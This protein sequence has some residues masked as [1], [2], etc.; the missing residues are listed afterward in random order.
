MEYVVFHAFCVVFLY[1]V[2]QFQVKKQVTCWKTTRH[3]ERLNASKNLGKN[4]RN[5]LQE[6]CCARQIT[7]TSLIAKSTKKTALTNLLAVTSELLDWRMC[8]LAKQGEAAILQERGKGAKCHPEGKRNKEEQG[9]HGGIIS[10]CYKQ[11]PAAQGSCSSTGVLHTWSCKKKNVAVFFVCFI[12]KRP[13]I[14]S[15]SAPFSAWSPKEQELM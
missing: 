1:Y 4:L 2:W 9:M 11:A 13:F 15:P 10:Q 7:S 12:P 14:S 8:P 3:S 6:A 5:L